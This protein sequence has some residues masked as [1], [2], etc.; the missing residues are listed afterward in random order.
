MGEPK[1]TVDQKPDY[2]GFPKAGE[3][4]EITGTGALSLH[5][6][7]VFNVLLQAAGPRLCDDVKHR[8]PIREVR[9]NHK[10]KERVKDSVLQLMRTIV[11]VPVAG[12]NGKPATKFVQLL[13]E[14]TISDDDE[15]PTGEVVFQFPEGLRQILSQSMHWGRLRGQV[16][17][18]FTSKYSLNLYELL[19]MRVNLA[20]KDSQIFGMDELRAL[21]GVP[22]DK[23]T[24][25]PDFLR[26]VIQPAVIEV[27]GVSDFGVEVEPIRR[28]GTMRGIITGFQVIWWRKSIPELHKAHAEL[29]RPKVGRLARLTDTA[30]TVEPTPL[31]SDLVNYL[32]D[33][34]RA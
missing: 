15:D 21:L 2:Q 11:T 12:R 22:D 25:N 8:I 23:L 14:T 20:H 26:K 7:R 4:I 31:Q 16:I 27:N 18:A 30:E 10:G 28:G 13:A 3:L 9:G 29:A 6:R 17:F 32:A 1:R 34:S 5:D 19:S 24:R 33:K